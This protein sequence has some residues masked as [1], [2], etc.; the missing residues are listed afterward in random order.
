MFLVFLNGTFELCAQVWEGLEMMPPQA[1]VQHPTHGA[2]LSRDSTASGVHVAACAR[3]KT[4]TKRRAF[5]AFLLQNSPTG[6]ISSRQMTVRMGARMGAD[7]LKQQ[8]KK[9]GY[10]VDSSTLIDE[11]LR[12]VANNPAASERA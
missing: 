4:P 11:G 2:K 7:G 12:R 8:Q 3:R 9:M 10:T 5:A 6:L 1:A